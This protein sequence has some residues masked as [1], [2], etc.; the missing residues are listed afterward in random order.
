MLECRERLRVKVEHYRR[1]L[2]SLN[3]KITEQAEQHSKQLHQVRDFYSNI[4][5]SRNRAGGIVK[6]AL[7]NS[8]AAADLMK[9]LGAQYGS[10]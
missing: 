5:Y 3:D 7:E 8:C 10:K 1:E 6:K 2:E 4:A 9:E